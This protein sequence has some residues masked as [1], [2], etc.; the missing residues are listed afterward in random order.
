MWVVVWEQKGAYSRPLLRIRSDSRR[1][2]TIVCVISVVQASRIDPCSINDHSL[3]NIS[4]KDRSQRNQG[5][6][7]GL[8]EA[9]IAGFSYWNFLNSSKA[10]YKNSFLLCFIIQIDS[11]MYICV[12]NT[13]LCWFRVLYIWNNDWCKR[14]LQKTWSYPWFL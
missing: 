6:I 13:N 11:N 12:N 3:K 4:K 14:L 8:S 2:E 9:K 7:L 10:Q 1:E 5:S